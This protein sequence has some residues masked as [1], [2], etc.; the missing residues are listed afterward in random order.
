MGVMA[1]AIQWYGGERLSAR[2]LR[3]T[4]SIWIVGAFASLVLLMVLRAAFVIDLPTEGGRQSV[5]FVI[6]W[7]RLSDCPCAQQSDALCISE[8][9]TFSPTQLERCWGA[10]SLRLA[11]LLLQ[12]NY[13][14]LLGCFG[15]LVG[16]VVLREGLPN[17]ASG[18]YDAQKGRTTQ[19]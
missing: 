14:A 13:L 17:A 7:S 4:F 11:Q 10:R 3:R 6:G 2:W 1:V 19:S 15:T 16:L 18:R 9:L 5:A 8:T 12:V